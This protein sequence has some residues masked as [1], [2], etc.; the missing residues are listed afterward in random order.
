M[1]TPQML[2]QFTQTRKKDLRKLMAQES[3]L[4]IKA[5]T[6]WLKVL[7]P[8]QYITTNWNRFEVNFGSVLTLSSCAYE[9]N[10]KRLF[11]T[12]WATEGFINNHV[13]VWSQ[14]LTM[15]PL[16]N[17][18]QAYSLINQEETQ[19]G[20]DNNLVQAMHTNNG[21]LVLFQAKNMN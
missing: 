10:F 18:S 5:S 15:R 16:H 9:W 11:E 19:R 4:C 13:I 12:Q 1:C 7:I 2:V 8:S 17:L 3:F 20:V 14:I 6:S 21:S